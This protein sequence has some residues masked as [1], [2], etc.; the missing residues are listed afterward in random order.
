MIYNR[1]SR[2][3]GCLLILAGLVWSAGV[4]AQAGQEGSPLSIG[5]LRKLH[6]EILKEDRPLSICLPSDYGRTRLS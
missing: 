3:L 4:F 1:T 2:W 5:T 6:S